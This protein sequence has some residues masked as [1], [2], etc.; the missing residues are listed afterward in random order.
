[1]R[2]ARSEAV[3]RNGGVV[4]C[5]SANPE[6]IDA[7]CAAGTL[8]G[9]ESGWIIFHDLDNDGDRAVGEPLLRAQLPSNFINSISEPGASTVFKFTATGRLGATSAT[10]LQFGKLPEFDSLVQR[11]VCVNMSGRV[12]IALDGNGRA[13]GDALCSTDR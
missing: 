12:R 11:M 1:M 3:R 2:F 9:W 13:T 10:Q 4:M 5:R 8:A 7:S 6:A